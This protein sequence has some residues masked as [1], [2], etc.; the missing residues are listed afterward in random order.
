MYVH[1]SA[2]LK[3]VSY[4]SACVVCLSGEL[5]CAFFVLCAFLSISSDLVCVGKV[6]FLSS[7][8]LSSVLAHVFH[9]C[10]CLSETQVMGGSAKGSLV[11][12]QASVWWCL[13]WYVYVY[14]KAWN[15]LW[16]WTVEAMPTPLTKTWINMDGCVALFNRMPYSSSL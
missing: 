15:L 6:G 5:C 7:F 16:E 3:V 14:V 13:A 1:E 4:S 12:H 11:T 2:V 10:S 9:V 8:F